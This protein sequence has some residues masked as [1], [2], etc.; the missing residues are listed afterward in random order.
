[1]TYNFRFFGSSLRPVVSEV[2]GMSMVGS[3]LKSQNL[4]VP[5]PVEET[6]VDLQI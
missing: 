4:K 5:I 3:N 6:L 2:T 1:M